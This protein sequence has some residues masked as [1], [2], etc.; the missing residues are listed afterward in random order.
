MGDS[1]GN[2]VAKVCNA[3]DSFAFLISIT[4]NLFFFWYW[5][6]WFFDTQYNQKRLWLLLCGFGKNQ[7]WAAK[8][9]RNKNKKNQNYI[10]IEMM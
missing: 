5:N 6:L 1:C 10:I 9:K 4:F 3:V 7:F 2:K 8:K